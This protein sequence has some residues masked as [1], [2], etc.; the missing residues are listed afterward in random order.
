MSHIL[1][2]THFP[3]ADHP[4]QS[5]PSPIAL[6]VLL[7]RGRPEPCWI[8]P[9]IVPQGVT[10]LAG[11]P[12][13]GKSWLALELA[14]AVADGRDALGKFPTIGGES[15]FVGLEDTQ[16]RMYD[17]ACKLFQGGRAPHNFL[18]A[19]YWNALCTSGLAD[20]EDWLQAHSETRLIVIDT[21]AQTGAT[22]SMH[23][24]MRPET[25]GV[26][27]PLQVLAETY[28]VAILLIHHLRKS[29]AGDPLDDV[30][31]ASLAHAVDCSM[32]LQRERGQ[33]QATLHVSGREV[34]FRTL[35][36]AFDEL[37]AHWTL[38]D[39]IDA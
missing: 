25:L 17:R 3:E 32:L 15:L 21:L 20:L 39:P 33:A 30:R 22:H 11:R 13:T 35:N 27:L 19:G 26:I 18:W 9:G 12:G 16:Q 5:L 37:T 14:L 38:T 23:G 1:S 29:G 24:G 31:F 34:T 2:S 8:I 4:N 7:D 28:H 6:D 10:L 36:L